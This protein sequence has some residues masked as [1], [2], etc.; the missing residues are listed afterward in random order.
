MATRSAPRP[1]T[2]ARSRSCSSA[3][4]TTRSP[5]RAATYTLGQADLDGANT[6][7]AVAVPLPDK[8]VVTNYNKPH[9]GAAEWWSGSGD[10][11][12]NSLTRE[13]DLTGK[14]SA[15]MS[16]WL[17][18]TTE[19][20]YDYFFVQASADGGANWTDLEV[21]DGASN[22][23]VQKTW[24]LGAFA[25]KKAQVRFRY[26][27]DGGVAE[28]GVF[29]DDIAVT[30]DGAPLSSPTTSRPAPTAGRPRASRS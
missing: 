1:A 2:W 7:Q 30:A 8:N 17:D 11:L 15:S 25:G 19:A 4:S 9:S 23:W 12:K 13:V 5:T 10:D 3:G 6:P 22:G 14:T 21:I 24:N 16:A 26:V 29:V 28:K 27:T 18:H 20:D